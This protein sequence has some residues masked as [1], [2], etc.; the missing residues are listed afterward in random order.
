MY[1]LS[2]RIALIYSRR[3]RECRVAPKLALELTQLANELYEDLIQSVVLKGGFEWCWSYV[4][5]WFPEDGWRWASVCG[6]SWTELL[7]AIRPQYW[8]HTNFVIGEIEVNDW[9]LAGTLYT[10]LDL[11][12]TNCLRWLELCISCLCMSCMGTPKLWEWGSV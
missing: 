2:W 12:A 5:A 7:K 4:S 10:V 6:V 8:T 3:S 9:P 11:S 1:Y